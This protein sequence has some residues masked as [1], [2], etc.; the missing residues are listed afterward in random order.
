MLYMYMHTWILTHSIVYIT[1]DYHIYTCTYVTLYTYTHAYFCMCM[2]T[3]IGDY[4]CGTHVCGALTC[5]V[6]TCKLAYALTRV[7][8]AA[9][10]DRL[11]GRDDSR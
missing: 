1:T 8:G 7:F 9:F 6:V 4:M 5:A 3:Y 2:Q 11:Q 10:G